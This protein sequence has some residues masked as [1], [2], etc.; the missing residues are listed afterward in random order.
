MP[1]TPSVRSLTDAFGRTLDSAGNL[2]GAVEAFCE[3]TYEGMYENPLHPNQARRVVGLAFLGV[4]AA[5]EEFQEAV[6]V[7]Y[8]AGARAP[9]G[10][11]PAARAGTA[12][13]LQHAYDLLAGVHE[14][15]ITTQY[16]TWSSTKEV[17]GRAKIFFSHGSPFV[18][19]LTH[20]QDRLGD[21]FSIRNRIAHGSRKSRS[22]FKR[23]A[24]Q[25]L[26]RP[27]TAKLSQGYSAGD[28]L[29]ERAAR[30]FPSLPAQP[31]Y[32]LAYLSMFSD[33]QERLVP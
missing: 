24:L 15:K 2:Y 20:W 28:L 21:A 14:F 17:I 12:Q 13:S 31:T 23:V 5:W 33:L 16:L 25:H 9:S 6:F 1:R 22:D 32:F 26:G 18:G 7:R 8:L 10:F 3:R 29:M 27:L 11:M 4:V 30:G 19:A